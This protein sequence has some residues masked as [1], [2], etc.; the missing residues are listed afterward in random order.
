MWA[1][2]LQ[3]EDFRRLKTHNKG[4]HPRPG[5][6]GTMAD[7]FRPP[8]ALN[9]RYVRASFQYWGHL[10]KKIHCAHKLT[11]QMLQDEEQIASS[12][13]PIDMNKSPWLIIWLCVWSRHGSATWKRT[14]LSECASHGRLRQSAPSSWM[15]VV[16][17]LDVRRR[18]C[19]E[20][21]TWTWSLTVIWSCAFWEKVR[22]AQRRNLQSFVQETST[23]TTPFYVSAS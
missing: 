14:D 6:D 10:T 12:C 23:L 20:G 21:S 22:S 7:N 9:G 11:L 8:Q 15:D 18:F 1:I 19:Q 13:L 5:D 2:P 16:S 3:M 4:D 17:L